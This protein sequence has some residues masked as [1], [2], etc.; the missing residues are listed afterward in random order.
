MDEDPEF[1]KIR[2]NIGKKNDDCIIHID[3]PNKRDYTKSKS[4]CKK[5]INQS[6]LAKR[7]YIQ[8]DSSEPNET[9]QEKEEDIFS[10]ILKQKDED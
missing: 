9:E 1:E 4:D 10:K 2:K 3:N 8:L 6:I 7:K 5:V